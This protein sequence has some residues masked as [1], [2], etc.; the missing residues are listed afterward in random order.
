MLDNARD[1]AQLRPLLPG[2]PGCLVLATSRRQLTGLVI[3]GGA[4][5]LTLGLLS[6]DEARELLARLLGAARVAAEPRAADELIE[7]CGGLP[8]A[9]AS[10]PP[11]RSS[12]RG[13][14]WPRLASEL[15]GASGTGST[16]STPGEAPA[17]VRAVF[18]WSYESLTG[19]AARMFRLLGAHPGPDITAPAA[20]SLA[21]V[22]LAQAR[23]ALDELASAHL[24]AEQP[25]GRYH[26]HDLLQA[27]AAEQLRARQPPASRNPSTPRP[28]AGC[29]IITC[30]P[31][32][33]CRS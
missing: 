7:L 12:G 31:L 27:Y 14:R 22:P 9:L 24:V 3:T 11:A 32:T 8:L 21:A 19:P 16:R 1:P 17:S 26:L 23:K 25:P 10:R 33:R 6:W 5:G 13:P 29:L 28:K 4:H 20:A 15:R 18:S 30:T 2:T